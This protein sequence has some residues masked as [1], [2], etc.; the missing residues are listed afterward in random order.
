MRTEDMR[1]MIVAAGGS[2]DDLPDNL[3]STLQKRLIET[4]GGNCPEGNLPSDI[5]NAFG[6]CGGA[7]NVVLGDIPSSMETTAEGFAAYVTELVIPEGVTD[8]QRTYTDDINYTF[9]VFPDFKNLKK[10]TLPASMTTVPSHL[11]CMDTWEVPYTDFEVVLSHGITKIGSSAFAY[12]ELSK[13]TIPDSVVEIAYAAFECCEKLTEIE[14]PSSVTTIDGAAFMDSA[15]A[16]IIIHK[17]ENSIEGAA[18]WGDGMEV[19]WTG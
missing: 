13:I 14:I 6:S 18:D 17:P 7:Q 16:K 10:I 2:V 12:S 8:L 11:L 5:C 4:M 19:I 3:P 9:V 1:N 15:I